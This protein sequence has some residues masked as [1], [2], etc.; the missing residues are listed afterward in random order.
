M[1]G[2]VRHTVLHSEKQKLPY[3]FKRQ[4][5]YYFCY[6]VPAIFRQCGM[7]RKFFRI[8]L[9][10]KS[11]V[12]ARKSVN[13][14][15]TQIEEAKE[16]L[17][18]KNIKQGLI[19][20]FNFCGID[21]VKVQVRDNDGQ[22]NSEKELAVLERIAAL[23]ADYPASNTKKEVKS[24]TKI[25]TIKSLYEQWKVSWEEKKLSEKER[26]NHVRN[27]SILLH[28]YGDKEPES[29]TPKQADRVL[30]IALRMPK[31]NKTPYNKMNNIERIKAAIDSKVPD[32]DRVA[33]FK[34]VLKTCQGFY[35][36]MASKY[37]VNNKPFNDRRIKNPVQAKRGAFTAAEVQRIVN[38]S[39]QQEDAN[40]K[41]VPLIMAFTG[42]RN[43]EIQ[44]LER[45]QF[46]VCEE[47]GL[48]YIQVGIT[49]SKIGNVKTTAGIRRVP[50]AQA[51]IDFGI[52]DYIH[53]FSKPNER[54]FLLRKKWL[55]VYFASTLKKECLLPSHDTSGDM[56]SI[57][58]T[59][60]SVVS[61][62]RSQGANEAISSAIVGHESGQTVHDGYT[63][64]AL[65]PIIEL[66]NYI[67]GLPWAVHI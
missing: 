30:S 50:L 43:S 44:N 27:M 24:Q 55:T 64:K 32:E 15:V 21:K 48:H 54:I 19:E 7:T 29:I 5:I 65:I 20:V 47:T 33:G 62:I 36:W 26:L 28:L 18:A 41:W 14:L 35:S 49:N 1:R 39:S 31:S 9:H 13:S 22:D 10:T 40:K 67:D 58:S 17:V 4:G 23:N 3:T 8:S 38:F 52:L 59:R 12:K 57:Y 42:M 11:H 53:S 61:F 37:L 51:L 45:Y 60:H 6:R 25:L 16:I 34:P 63:N 56:L 66:K 46:K 2:L